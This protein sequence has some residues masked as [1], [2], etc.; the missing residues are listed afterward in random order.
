[1]TMMRS[2][3]TLCLVLFCAGFG[4][5]SYSADIGHSQKIPAATCADFLAQLRKKPVHVTFV[6]CTAEPERQGKPLRASYHVRG[7][8]AAQAEAALIRSAGLNKL[9]RSCCQWDSPAATYRSETGQ[10]FMVTMV[11]Q[12]TPVAKRTQWRKIPRFEIIVEL[13]TE[14][15]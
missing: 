2:V 10:E 6:K 8:H 7:K 13:L 9:K 15:I 12:E 3:L 11:S 14:D 1:M 4:S 5:R